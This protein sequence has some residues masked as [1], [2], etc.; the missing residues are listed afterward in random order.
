MANPKFEVGA[1]VYMVESAK[2]GS[3]ESYTISESRQGLDKSWVYNIAIAAKTPSI[4]STV[5][6]RITL[7]HSINFSLVESDLTD[8]CTAVGLAKGYLETQLERITRIESTYCGG[9]S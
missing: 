5:G 3:L 9:T 6:D 1:T 2:L 7:K 4:N 8:F